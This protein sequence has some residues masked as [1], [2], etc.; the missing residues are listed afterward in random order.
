LK[1]DAVVEG[2]P[3]LLIQTV[4][5]GPAA[6]LPANRPHYSNTMPPFA[7]LSDP[8]IA[9]LLTYIRHQ[10][11]NGAS[12]VGPKDVATTRDLPQKQSD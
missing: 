10:F 12:A 4:L 7:R 9:A 8:Q 6:T 2:A 3:T 5:K 1:G 11:G